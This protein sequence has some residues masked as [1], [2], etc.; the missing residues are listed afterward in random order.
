MTARR[1]LLPAATRERPAPPSVLEWGPIFEWRQRKQMQQL[2]PEIALRI[3]R[4]IRAGRPVEQAIA[5]AATTGHVALVRIDSQLN[6]G[7]PLPDAIGDWLDR[8]ESDAERLLAA[9]IELGSE[10]GGD[11]ARSLDIVGEGIR[12]DI[13]LDARR[14]TLLT[15]SR[16]SAAVLV[17]L[18]V[19]FAALASLLQGGLIYRGW[20]GLTLLVVGG[21]LDAIGLLW[22]KRLLRGLK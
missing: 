5:D 22:I 17:A 3:G 13:Q 7:R 6:A 12:D 1:P 16:L 2:L 15:Q 9:A 14:R 19:V 11:L 10:R 8:C 20:V 4:S 18:P 21:G